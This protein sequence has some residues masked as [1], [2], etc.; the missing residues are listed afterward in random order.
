[1]GRVA[2]TKPGKDAGSANMWTYWRD[3]GRSSAP[4]DGG[5]ERGM[6]CLKGHLLKARVDLDQAVG[7]PVGVVNQLDVRAGSGAD[8]GALVGVPC[9]VGEVVA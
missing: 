1:M 8:A 6:Y 9:Q 4:R 2:S 5:P 3:R 7:D